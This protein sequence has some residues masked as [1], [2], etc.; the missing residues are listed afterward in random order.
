M[1]FRKITYSD[2]TVQKT[3]HRTNEQPIQYRNV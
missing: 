3:E 1:E 2:N